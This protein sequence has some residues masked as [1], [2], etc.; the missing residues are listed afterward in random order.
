M[1]KTSKLPKILFIKGVFKKDCVS[2]D[3]FEKKILEN[4]TIDNM[5]ILQQEN[6]QLSTEYNFTNYIKL[7]NVFTNIDSW[8]KTTN[9]LCWYCGQTFTTVPVFI[10]GVIEP[11]MSKSHEERESAGQQVLIS[12][13]GVFSSFGCAYAYVQEHSF[14][15]SE[16]TE[17]CCKLQLLHKL[18]Y[19]KKMKDI[20]EYPKPYVMKQYGGDLTIEEF[21]KLMEKCNIEQK[22]KKGKQTFDEQ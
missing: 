3:I 8:P 11:V 10:P 9:L 18:F 5:Q 22:P 17:M 13:S 14:S 7:P 2:D 19:G 1:I 4:I 6:D 16:K 12:T 15:L 21:N 20:S